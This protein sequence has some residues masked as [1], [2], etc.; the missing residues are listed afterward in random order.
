LLFTFGLMAGDRAR[1]SGAR[2]Q[3]IDRPSR[4]KSKERVFQSEDEKNLAKRGR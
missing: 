2:L 3:K 1:L 4:L